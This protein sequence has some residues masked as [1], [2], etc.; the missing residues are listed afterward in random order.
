MSLRRDVISFYKSVLRISKNWTA[1]DSAN[2]LAEKEFI[3]ER[4]RIEVK[5]LQKISNVDQQKAYLAKM[6]NWLETSVHYRIPY[7]KPYH[8]PTGTLKKSKRLIK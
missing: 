8:Y 2:T 4:A 6:Y 1:I 5:E 3:K 7:S